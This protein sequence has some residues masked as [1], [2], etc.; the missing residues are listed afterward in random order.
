MVLASFQIL[1][2]MGTVCSSHA[3]T[4]V[5]VELHELASS[6]LS[7][8]DPAF[9]WHTVSIYN[10]EKCTRL[11]K[12][13]WKRYSCQGQFHF[14]DICPR[15]GNQVGTTYSLWYNVLSEGRICPDIGKY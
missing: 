11:E 7:K 9:D 8:G 12:E 13:G 5:A 10:P 15:T 14:Q 2:S 3:S 1:N 6:P 4:A